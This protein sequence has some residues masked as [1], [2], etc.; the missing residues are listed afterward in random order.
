MCRLLILA[1]L[2]A[3]LAPSLGC[4]KSSNAGQPRIQG[5]EPTNLVPAGVSGGGGPKAKSN[6]PV[7]GSQ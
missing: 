2:L 3:F 4:S 7:S 6:Q 5:P 1:F